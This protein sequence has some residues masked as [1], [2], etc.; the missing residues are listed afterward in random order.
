MES[1]EKIEDVFLFVAE[2]EGWEFGWNGNAATGT[3][4][5][6]VIL[7]LISWLLSV[8]CVVLSCKELRSMKKYWSTTFHDSTQKPIVFD[9]SDMWV[10]QMRPGFSKYVKILPFDTYFPWISA[11]K[12]SR[13]NNNWWFRLAVDYPNNPILQSS[14]ARQISLK[15]ESPPILTTILIT[16]WISIPPTKLHLMFRGEIFG[17]DAGFVSWLQ[18]WKTDHRPVRNGSCLLPNPNT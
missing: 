7:L 18:S 17:D 15:T 16:Y 13:K 11:Q 4:H 10:L 6:C 2:I 1:I 9:K 8:R 14:S 5:N 12:L 3:H